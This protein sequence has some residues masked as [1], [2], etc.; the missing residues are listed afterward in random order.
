VSD[1]P[2]VEARSE[3]FSPIRGDQIPADCHE[4]TTEN[5]NPGTFVEDTHRD[6][7]GGADGRSSKRR[8]ERD[9]VFQPSDVSDI[10][11]RKAVASQRW[12]LHSRV[13][14]A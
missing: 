12:S 6:S 4:Q 11:R 7:T 3:R 2:S 10:G 5:G 9:T 13:R 1:N 8:D 14:R